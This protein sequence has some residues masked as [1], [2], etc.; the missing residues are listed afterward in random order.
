VSTIDSLI[1]EMRVSHRQ[2][3]ADFAEVKRLLCRFA[4]GSSEF[5]SVKEV[6][7]RFQVSVDTVRRLVRAGKL[8]ASRIGGRRGQLRFDPVDLKR[9]QRE[10]AG[11]T[12][13]PAR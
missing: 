5:L 13:R 7:D 1:D 4:E 8:P 12:W 10:S 9:F 6:A 2:F 11:F 3:A